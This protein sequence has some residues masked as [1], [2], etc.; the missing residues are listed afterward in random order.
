MLS[1]HSVIEEV[2]CD[3]DESIYYFKTVENDNRKALGP[4]LL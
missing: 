4:T 3:V 2:W 1:S